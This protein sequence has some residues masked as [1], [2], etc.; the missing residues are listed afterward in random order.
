[1]TK[2]QKCIKNYIACKEFSHFFAS[3]IRIVKGSYSLCIKKQYH[4]H[5]GE[6]VGG[7]HSFS[8]TQVQFFF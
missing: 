3:E 6:G 7:R 2:Q 8:P 5:G 4:P 1:M